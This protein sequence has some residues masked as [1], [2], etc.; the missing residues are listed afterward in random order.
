MNIVQHAGDC[1]ANIA[2]R[3]TQG[4]IRFPFLASIELQRFG[5][6]AVFM[7]MLMGQL[8]ILS[9]ILCGKGCSSD[10]HAAQGRQQQ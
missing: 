1:L 9:A 4:A 2:H 8:T 6:N 7:S 3:L 5:C 10:S